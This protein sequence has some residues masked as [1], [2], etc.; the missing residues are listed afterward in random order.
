MSPP[1]AAFY[2]DLASPL[3]YLAAERVL[4]T[5][6][7]ATEW[8]P[9]LA[10]ELPAAESFEAFRC[11]N[12]EEIFRLEI[13]PSC[14]RTGPAGSALAR[15]VPVRQRLCDAR[16]HLREV[17]RPDRRLRA[18]RIPPG[19]CRRTLA[20]RGRQRADRGSR[21]RDAPVRRAEGRRV[22]LGRASS[23]RPLPGG[24]GA[25]CRATC[26]R[27]VSGSACSTASAPW[28]TRRHTHVSA[29][30]LARARRERYGRR[31]G[32]HSRRRREETHTVRANRCFR[33]IVRR[34]GLAPGV[35]GQP[36]PHRPH[37]GGRDRRRRGRVLLG[38]PAPDASRRAREVREDL[39][40]WIART[41]SRAG[42][43]WKR[44]EHQ[45][46]RACP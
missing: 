30:A 9:V 28:R 16:G 33:L 3:A 8:Q 36:R 5:M 4:H 12:D 38:L 31:G 17:D 20:R 25:R 1:D 21:L 2:F 11:R 24:R 46:M 13:V 14:R 27:C 42:V 18:G 39:A 29:P 35:P 10:R 6:P 32:G 7:I 19:V 15:P 40:G 23:C 22:A 37:R 43:P 34:G 45:G 41:S 26:R 44:D